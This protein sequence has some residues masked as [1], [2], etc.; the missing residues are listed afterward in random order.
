MAYVLTLKELCIIVLAQHVRLLSDDQLDLI[1]CTFTLY[2][3]SSCRTSRCF[4]RT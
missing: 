2:Y 4:L 1:C 3:K